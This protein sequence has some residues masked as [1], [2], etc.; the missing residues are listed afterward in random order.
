MFVADEEMF[1][2]D[3]EV[4]VFMS[5]YNEIHAL[6]FMHEMHPSANSIDEH[7]YILN[8]SAKWTS[9]F[10]GVQLHGYLVAGLA[11]L[12]FSLSCMARVAWLVHVAQNLEGMHIRRQMDRRLCS[13]F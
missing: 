1:V 10:P 3:E 12:V 2:V 4:L 11:C 5:I 13:K 9:A 7:M 6:V 8:V